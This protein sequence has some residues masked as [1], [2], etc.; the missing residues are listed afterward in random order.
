ML[1]TYFAKNFRYETKCVLS[2]GG[3]GLHFSRSNK[4]DWDQTRDTSESKDN[5]E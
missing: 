4:S 2:G 1:L 5:T 3:T